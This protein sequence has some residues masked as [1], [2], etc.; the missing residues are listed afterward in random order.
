MSPVRAD[1][2]DSHEQQD[3]RHCVSLRK[4]LHGIVHSFA[5]LVSRQVWTTTQNR[6]GRCFLTHH[7]FSYG[8]RLLLVPPSHYSASMSSLSN[9]GE[10]DLRPYL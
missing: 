2:T 6:A 9:Q 1:A 4:A 7:V 8:I 3:R 10:R 5:S